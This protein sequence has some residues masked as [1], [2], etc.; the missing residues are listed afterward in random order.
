MAVSF[1]MLLSSLVCCSCRE[2]HAE[3]PGDQRA[4]AEVDEKR[5]L[6]DAVRLVKAGQLEKAAKRL[7]L[8]KLAPAAEETLQKLD[9]LHPALTGRRREVEEDR[10]WELQAQALELDEGAALDRHPEWICVKADT[11]NAFNAAHRKAMFAAVERDFPEL[12]A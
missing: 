8:A 5:V 12:W 4:T 10:R 3:A 2:L 11:K 9:R 1:Q 6:R 7:E